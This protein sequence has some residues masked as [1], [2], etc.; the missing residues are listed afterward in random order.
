[1]HLD[2]LQVP[3]A[4][5]ETEV[6]RLIAEREEARRARDFSK[7]DRIRDGL[8]ERGILLEDS[9]DGVRWRLGRA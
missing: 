9:R 6:R 5:L 8:R 7:A 3:E 4:E 1:V 2:I